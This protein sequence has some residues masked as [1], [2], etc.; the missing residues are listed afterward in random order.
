MKHSSQF[1]VVLKLSKRLIRRG[2]LY[3][4][5]STTWNKADSFWRLWATVMFLLVHIL[6]D[7]RETMFK[8]IWLWVNAPLCKVRFILLYNRLFKKPTDDQYEAC[9][10]YFWLWFWWFPLCHCPSEHRLDC[11]SVLLEPPQGVLLSP[12]LVPQ[13]TPRHTGPF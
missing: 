1:A 13:G 2:K 7:W 10:L 3:I 5:T 8:M 11:V 9:R 12:F 4:L 6:N